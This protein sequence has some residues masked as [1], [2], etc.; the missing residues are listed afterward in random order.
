VAYKAD[1]RQD[2][3]AGIDE[4]MDELTVLPPSI[5]DPTTRLD[6][7]STTLT[8]VN[9]VTLELRPIVVAIQ[10]ALVRTYWIDE[11]LD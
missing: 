9:Y 1:S 7:P 6:P 2:I 4:Y 10:W 11:Q 8:M 3:L 5:W